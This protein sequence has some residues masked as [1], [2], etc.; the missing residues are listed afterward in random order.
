MHL[1]VRLTNQKIKK[2]VSTTQV[3]AQAIK[4]QILPSH[5]GLV[6]LSHDSLVILVKIIEK[7]TF[8]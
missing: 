5:D 7:S 3:S 1:I 4:L 2:Q 6:V 8:N